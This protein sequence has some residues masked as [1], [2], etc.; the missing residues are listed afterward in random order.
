MRALLAAAA[1]IATPQIADAVEEPAHDVVVKDGKFEIRAYEPM[2]MATVVVDAEQRRAPNAG[3]RPLANFIFGDNTTQAEIEMTAPVVQ[4]RSV[5]I[6]MTAP[7]TQ[8]AAEPGGWSIGFVMPSEWTME[9]L[10]EPNDPNV[11]LSEQPARVVA[12]VK[13]AGGIN[14]GRQSRKQAELEAWIVDQGYQAVGAPTFAY[15]DPPWIPGPFRRNEV[16]IEVEK[17]E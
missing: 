6:A 3:F 7:V 5:E 9:T 17:A 8:S 14:P 16:L 2:I 12:S 4:T 10:P 11:T 15:Y 13:F 1:L